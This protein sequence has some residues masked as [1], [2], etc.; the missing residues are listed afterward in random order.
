[1][2]NP[3]LDITNL[4]V[5]YDTPTGNIQALNGVSF[6]LFEEQKNIFRK[7]D[8]FVTSSDVS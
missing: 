7:F 3:I 6:D 4:Y 1:M 2:T 8:F 5:E